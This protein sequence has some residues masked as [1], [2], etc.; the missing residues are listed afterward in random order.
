VQ[1]S[2]SVVLTTTLHTTGMKSALALIAASVIS[3]VAA[4]VGSSAGQALLKGRIAVPAV[5]TNNSL[6]L[7]DTTRVDNRPPG[8]LPCENK[9]GQYAPPGYYCCDNSTLYIG[10]VRGRT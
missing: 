4:A 9:P 1:T 6:G 10:T 3:T 8:Y 5:H 7:R 2:S